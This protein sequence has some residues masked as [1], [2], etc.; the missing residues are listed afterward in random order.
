[1]SVSCC[2]DDEMTSPIELQH[3]IFNCFCFFSLS[4]KRYEEGAIDN[5][6]N[7]IETALIRNTSSSSTM[8][9]NVVTHE[10]A[11]NADCEY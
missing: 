4:F 11:F 5:I 10:M 7:F 1:M 9:S 3:C 2:P 6:K 8:P